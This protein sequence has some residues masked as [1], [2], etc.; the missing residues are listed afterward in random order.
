ML[1]ILSS[2]VV[3]GLTKRI[4]NSK[5]F[6]LSTDEVTDISNVQTLVTFIKFFDMEKSDTSTVFV[7]SSDLLEESEEGSPNANAI[8]NCLVNMLDRLG[9]DLSHLKPFSSDG[10]SVMTDAE[11]GVA[12]K[13][14]EINDCKTMINVHCICHRL[15]L[16]C[17]DTRGE[18]QIVKD[19]ELTMTQ[20]WKFFKDSPKRIKLYIL[21]LQCN[22]KI[23][24]QCQKGKNE[25]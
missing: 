8:L 23:L 11:G 3:E 25:R 19:F 4:K 13:F 1:I 18:L 2:T 10:A 16:A 12:A 24:T 6:G 21:E 14:R 9:L 22:L 5:C 20:L 17:S 15:A 7:D